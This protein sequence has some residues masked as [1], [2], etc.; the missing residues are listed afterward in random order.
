MVPFNAYADIGTGFRVAFLN[1]VKLRIN[2][3]NLFDKDYL[4]AIS[5]TT[6]TPATFGPGPR[7]TFQISLTAAL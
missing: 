1:E 6:N 2:V 4:G 3:D 5:A 7:R